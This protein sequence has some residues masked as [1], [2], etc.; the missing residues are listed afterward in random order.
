[1]L[2]EIAA[3]LRARLEHWE[4]VAQTRPLTP[5]ELRWRASDRVALMLATLPEEE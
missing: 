1:M 5:E 4:R 2:A 3:R